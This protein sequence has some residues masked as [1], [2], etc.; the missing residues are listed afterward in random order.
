MTFPKMIPKFREKP[1]RRIAH[2]RKD[3]DQYNKEL[4]VANP[5]VVAVEKYINANT[6]IYHKCLKHNYTW[7]VPPSR[8]LEGQGCKYCRADKTRARDIWSNEYY[9]QKLNNINPLIIPLEQY[10]G[11]RYSIWHWFLDCGHLNKT[12]PMSILRTGK[13]L[14]CSDL[15]KGKNLRKPHDVFVKQLEAVNLYV[16]VLSKYQ[17]GHKKID[18]KCKICGFVWKADPSSLLKGV[19]CPACSMSRGERDIRWFLDRNNIRY[20]SQYSLDDLIGLGGGLLSYDFFLL[21]YNTLLEFQGEQHERAKSGYFGGEEQF[22]IQQEHDR[23]KRE[24]AKQHGF[25]LL[26]IW[27]YDYDRIEEILKEKLNLESLETVTEA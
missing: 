11:M 2:N 27:Y 18:C 20:I 13:C 22:A 12:S 23:R 26:E 3:A 24:Y 5:N 25:T 15:E 17:S 8:V 6:P 19:G 4:L 9:L 7:K 14:R 16:E 10:I 21:D 1:K